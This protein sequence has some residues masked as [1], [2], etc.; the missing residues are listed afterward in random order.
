LTGQGYA[1]ET[2]ECIP[3]LFGEKIQSPVENKSKPDEA[4]DSEDRKGFIELGKEYIVESAIL[5]KNQVASYLTGSSKTPTSEEL[6][7]QVKEGIDTASEKAKELKDTASEKAK[8]AKDTASEKTKEVKD[9]ASK[10]AKQGVEKA[11][12]EVDKASEKPMDVD[13]A[14]KKTKVEKP[15][16]D[17]AEDVDILGQKMAEGLQITVKV[18]TMA[19]KVEPNKS[20][21]VKAHAQGVVGD[22]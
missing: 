1:I 6:K 10:K 14:S 7:E 2:I 17:Q 20:I 13:T 21:Q 5:A 19:D 11:E 15:I 12:H 3:R 4:K 9:T 16:S 8:E 18:D 22:T